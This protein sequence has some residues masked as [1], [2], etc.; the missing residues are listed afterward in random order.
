MEREKVPFDTETVR[1]KEIE[2]N[3]KVK[4]RTKSDKSAVKLR[5]M[6]M[7]RDKR[8]ISLGD[9]VTKSKAVEPEVLF[10]GRTAFRAASFEAF[11][12]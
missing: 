11:V 1:V 3:L 10:H 6:M 5:T 4:L 7:S 12:T 9:R 8:T 2:F